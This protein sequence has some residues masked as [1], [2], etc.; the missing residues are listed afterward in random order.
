MWFK[1]DLTSK[2]LKT[3][4]DSELLIYCLQA[5]YILSCIWVCIVKDTVF[6]KVYSSSDMFAVCPGCYSLVC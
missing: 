6:P 1:G 2:K 3:Q 4:I 5:D